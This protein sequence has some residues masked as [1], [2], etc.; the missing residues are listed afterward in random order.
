MTQ[1]KNIDELENIISILIV[2]ILKTNDINYDF[3]KQI[4]SKNYGVIIFKKENENFVV[5]LTNCILKNHIVFNKSFSK[6]LCCVCFDECIYTL[7]CGH[8]ICKDCAKSWLNINNSC[9]VCRSCDNLKRGFIFTI[10]INIINDSKKKRNCL[11]F[12]RFKSNRYSSSILN[13][14][15]KKIRKIKS[16]R[17]VYI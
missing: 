16:G 6:D 7:K 12:R 2:E 14:K 3:T 5:N 8:F 1:W 9:P 13:K 15:L 4:L 11:C 17:Y 10:P